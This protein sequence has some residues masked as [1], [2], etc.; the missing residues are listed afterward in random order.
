MRYVSAEGGRWRQ[1]FD[2]RPVIIGGGGRRERVFPDELGVGEMAQG[3]LV[4][5]G[6]KRRVKIPAGTPEKPRLKQTRQSRITVDLIESDQKFAYRPVKS[7]H[8]DIGVRFDLTEAAESLAGR[9]LDSRPKLETA[10]RRKTTIPLSGLE[11]LKPTHQLFDLRHPFGTTAVAL[12]AGPSEFKLA[13][14]TNGDG[15]LGFGASRNYY[16]NLAAG[17]RQ[18]EA[19]STPSGDLH[20][21]VPWVR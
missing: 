20:P 14:L 3:L 16:H 12:A 15:G 8:P 11:P 18:T 5:A 2:Q 10:R 9:G 6:R 7:D 17:R 21:E 1:D 19:E 13:T 4:A